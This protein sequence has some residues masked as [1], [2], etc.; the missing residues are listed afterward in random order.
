MELKLDTSVPYALALEGGGA[1][2][3]YQIGAWKAL[4]EAGVR[5]EAVSG[6]SVGALN[7]ALIAMDD[8]EA[9]ERCWNEIRYSQVIDVDDDTMQKMFSGDL[10]ANDRKV[11]FDTIRQTMEN[12][13][14]D[15]TPLR[16]LLAATVKEEVLR[17][18]PVELFIVTYS[19][20]DRRELE[21]RAKDL[22]PGTIPDMLLA[23]AYLPVFRNEPLGGKRYADGGVRDVLPLH[24]LFENGYRNVIALRLYGIGLERRVSVP[25]DARVYTVSPTIELGG[26]LEFD[27]QRSRLNMKAGYFDARRLLYGLLGKRYYLK[28][29]RTEEE[30]YRLL[31][32]LVRRHL[33]R[34]GKT[35][36][37]RQIHEKLLPQLAR[38]LSAGKEDY[39][40]LLVTVLEAA[41]AELQL[42][43]W[44][45]YGLG[46][47]HELLQEQ[48]GAEGFSRVVSDALSPRKLLG[49]LEL[50]EL[51]L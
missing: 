33:E 46:E 12:G 26:T 48:Y 18:S 38:R 13:G 5:I 8:L 34:T 15:V 30:A 1:K 2:G 35:A 16:E 39:L 20:T 36:S 40:Q 32:A 21:L 24:V 14:F 51:P 6:T 49:A 17:D 44:R 3:A 22:A 45:I 4:R 41:A 42:D 31:A 11:I 27:A 43:P 19:V 25:R 29:D 10:D 47:L 37:L 7:G 9:A 50:P 23:S 28:N